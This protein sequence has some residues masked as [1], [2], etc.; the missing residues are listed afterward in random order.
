MWQRCHDTSPAVN[1]LAAGL[2]LFVSPEQACGTIWLMD[3]ETVWVKYVGSALPGNAE[4]VVLFSTVAA[5]PGALYLASHAL[6]RF[7]LSLMNDQAGTLKVFFSDNR[8]VTWTQYV[9]DDAVAAS[10]ANNDNERE[11]VGLAAYR[12]WKVEWLNGV[13][14][15]TSFKPNMYLTTDRSP[16]V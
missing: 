6:D 15:Q 8:G 13:T 5:F 4:T 3:N 7:R 14:P 2:V 16:P 1:P 12:D 11:Y 9:P 10:P